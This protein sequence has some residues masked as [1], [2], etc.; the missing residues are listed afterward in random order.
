MINDIVECRHCG[1]QHFAVSRKYA[2]DEVASF[3]K[4]FDSLSEEDKEF[5]YG[6]KKSYVRNYEH[7]NSCGKPADMVQPTKELFGSTI[8][9]II[10]KEEKP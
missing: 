9:P 10:W 1:W 5:Y 7:C 4:Y 6:G 3:N 2:E 8:G